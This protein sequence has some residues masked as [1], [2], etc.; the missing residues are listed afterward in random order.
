[1]HVFWTINF[2]IILD[3]ELLV[4]SCEFIIEKKDMP[5]KVSFHLPY[6]GCNLKRLLDLP[7][8]RTRDGCAHSCADVL[9]VS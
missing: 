7:S 4:C 9:L 8:S 3:L 2:N 1:M 5:L 6:L